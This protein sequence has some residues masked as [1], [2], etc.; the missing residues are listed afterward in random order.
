MSIGCNVTLQPNASHSLT[1][2][3]MSTAKRQ[4][5][6]HHQIKPI[7]YQNVTLLPKNVTDSVTNKLLIFNGNNRA[8]SAL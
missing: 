1:D 2:L 3:H 4:Q 7:K 5:K 8:E 6:R